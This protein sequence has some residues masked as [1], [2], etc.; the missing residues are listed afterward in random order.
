[1]GLRNQL[2]WVLEVCQVVE[3]QVCGLDHTQPSTAG[4][5]TERNVLLLPFCAAD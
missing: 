5:G 4:D 1:L 2:K 3:G